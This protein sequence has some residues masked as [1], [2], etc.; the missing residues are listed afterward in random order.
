M[1]FSVSGIS[2]F[3]WIMFVWSIVGGIFSSV[4]QEMDFSFNRSENEHTHRERN[5]DMAKRKY[6]VLAWSK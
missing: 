5:S 6:G 4:L 3:V 2:S 1:V